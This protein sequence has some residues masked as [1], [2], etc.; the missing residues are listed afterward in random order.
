VNWIGDFG[1][2]AWWTWALNNYSHFFLLAAG[3][4]GLP[5]GLR[6]TRGNKVGQIMVIGFGF[7]VLVAGLVMWL[8]KL[9]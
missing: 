5:I 1:W 9:L 6:A 2:I 7:M 4:I 3:T 8:L